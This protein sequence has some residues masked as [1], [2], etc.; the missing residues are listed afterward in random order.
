MGLS[1]TVLRMDF[2][3]IALVFSVLI[4]GYLL[5]RDKGDYV[6]ESA[7]YKRIMAIKGG[8]SVFS[9]EVDV[10]PGFHLLYASISRIFD[11]SSMP[12][13]RLLTTV[14][15]ALSVT[16]LYLTAK[17]ID[18]DSSHI[19]TVQFLLFPTFFPFFFL[20]YTDMLSL[21]LVLAS[22][23]LA[24]R[25]KY[26]FSGVFGILSMF[27]RQNNVIAV[28]FICAYLLWDEPNLRLDARTFRVM[29]RKIGVFVVG[30]LMLAVFFYF[31]GGI[32][33][34]GFIP[35]NA[36]EMTLSMGNVY[37]ALLLFFV[38]FLPLN[39]SN[40]G[41]VRQILGKKHL[42]YLLLLAFPLY[43]LT[44]GMDHPVN[45]SPDYILQDFF[46][47]FI[48]RSIIVKLM[49]FLSVAYSVISLVVT[50]LV[51]RVFYAAY[52]MS[53]IYLATLWIITPRYSIIPF[54][55]F[56]MFRKAE[57]IAVESALVVWIAALSIANY[58]GVIEG[59]FF[60]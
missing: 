42:V 29:L 19:R 35:N 50:P 5:I 51:R 26:A 30:L 28:M 46:I 34:T 18:T 40:F 4:S 7:H 45:S 17:V 54:S 32:R 52:P 3:V 13:F 20:V 21:F 37:F 27:V 56:L 25:E 22:F 57:S 11:F 41:R 43:I 55:F 14:F 48:K 12:S 39:I 38:I 60:P 10:I 59:L 24:V 49:V 1:A 44:L 6:D 15:S 9:N 58:S 33:V 8:D 31:N 16:V 23:Y 47:F 53:F 36:A 2:V